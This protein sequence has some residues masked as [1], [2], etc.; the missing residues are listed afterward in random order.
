A[1][2]HFSAARVAYELLVS[3]D[4]NSREQRRAAAVTI[5]QLADAEAAMGHTD[6]ARS[7]WL[8]ALGHLERLAASNTA[9]PRLEWAYGL[10]GYAMVERR[11]GRLTTA[12][13]TIERALRIVESTP[14]TN[15]LPSHAYYRAAVLAEIGRSRAAHRRWADAQQARQRAAEILR[16]LAA[17]VPMEA[18]WTEEL[19]QLEVALAPS[20]PA[21]APGP[22]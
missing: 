4:P 15:D 5:A 22:R 20:R 14:A 13:D 12:D 2:K 8:A 3:R 6:A 11:S 1:A 21:H 9:E 18:D 16:S 19:R 10:R 7:A 17:R